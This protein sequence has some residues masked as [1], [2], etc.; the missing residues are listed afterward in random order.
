VSTTNSASRARPPSPGA[1]DACGPVC[2]E[3]ERAGASTRPSVIDPSGLPKRS[4]LK[5]FLL[6][7]ALAIPFWLLGAFADRVFRSRWSFL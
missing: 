5:F 4:P 2:S 6:V 7:Y 3:P 1:G